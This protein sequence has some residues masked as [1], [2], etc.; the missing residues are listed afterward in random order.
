MSNLRFILKVL[1]FH[2]E[3]WAAY[4]LAQKKSQFENEFSAKPKHIGFLLRT[5]SFLLSIVKLMD[6]RKK[7]HGVEGADCLVFASTQNQATALKKTVCALHE[8]GMKLHCVISS[9]ALSH[10]ARSEN[11]NCN[12][13]TLR[14]FD[15]IQVIMIACVRAPFLWKYL[16]SQDHTLRQWYL[17]AFLRSYIYLVFFNQLLDA[18]DAKLVLV[19]NDHSAPH[20][21]LIA[22]ARV[23]GIRTAYIQH[24]SVLS[25]FPAL[26]FEY[27]LLDGSVALQRYRIAESNQPKGFPLPEKRH[28]F[29]TG[30]KKPVYPLGNLSR[31]R[32]GVAV[33]PSDSL[34]HIKAL[35]EN[36]NNAGFLLG[37]R[38]HPGMGESEKR[39]LTRLYSSSEIVVLSDPK[40]ESVGDFLQ[41][42]CALIAGN[43]SIHLEAALAGVVPIYYEISPVSRPDYYG[44]VENGL[45]IGVER[46]QLIAAISDAMAGQCV[47][48]QVAVRT[49]SATFNTEWEG[50]EGELAAGIL[51]HV[52][53]GGDPAQC[54]GY[55]GVIRCDSVMAC[56]RYC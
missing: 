27:A 17:D 31:E 30:Q 51:M 26:C 50:E 25:D 33:N 15:A 1:R 13:I 2:P 35:V 16:S 14:F 54:W 20:R 29:L 40:I 49:Y 6:L 28:V 5:A 12:N 19:S 53:E 32:V 36:L 48:D 18:I 44:Y 8:K 9:E 42:I 45:S 11:L 55:A 47:P 43:S 39:S 7:N 34:E 56:E 23:K 21:C 38:W 4:K 24:A 10:F 3:W 22:L 52:F 46:S 37:L 41:G